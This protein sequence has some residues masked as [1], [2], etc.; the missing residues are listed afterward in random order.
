[1]NKINFDNALSIKLL[2]NFEE[3]KND[4]LRG[5]EQ[6]EKNYQQ[7]EFLD[8]KAREEILDASYALEAVVYRSIIYN[9]NC[10]KSMQMELQ[11]LN[12]KVNNLAM[13]TDHEFLKAF[14]L[15]VFSLI[16]LYIIYEL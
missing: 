1:M 11:E 13:L 5:L 16:S 2:E 4:I 15:R 3:S 8:L 10:K 6:L 9:Q 14:N 12:S 7:G